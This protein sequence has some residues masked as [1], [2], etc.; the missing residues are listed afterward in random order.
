M[1]PLWTRSFTAL[2]VA[3]FFLATGFYLLLTSL[4]LYIVELGGTEAHV[5][6]LAFV[7]TISA[8]VLRP[9]VGGL[10][11]R[12]GRRQFVLGGLLLFAIS[13]FA[14]TRV[15]ELV[16]LTLV[17]VVHGLSWAITTTAIATAAS[18]VIPR[19][20]FG[21][22]MGWFG[23]S[24]TLGM[25]VGPLLPVALLPYI[26]YHGVFLVGC[27][28][29]V[30]SLMIARLAQMPFQPKERKPR[31]VLFNKA[32]LP[33]AA[34]VFFFAMVYSSIV[35]FLPLFAES[36]RV[37]KGLF[38]TVY[39]LF[40]LVVRAFSGRLA[41]RHGAAPV[42]VPGLVS[43]TL[44]MLVLWQTETV[45]GIVFAAILFSIAFGSAHPILQATALRLVPPGQKGVA[46]ATYISAFDLGIGLGSVLLGRIAEAQGF[47]AM[48]LA[49]ALFGAIALLIYL[50]F[51]RRIGGRELLQEA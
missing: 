34:T 51:A 10:L 7:F 31:V 47:A 5:G 40:L 29:A 50:Y 37:N 26:S 13:M 43:A 41:D 28:L 45:R 30:T 9:F 17:R 8:M 22:G 11:D 38:F 3:M 23:M 25:A 19:R 33:V 27:G 4:P 6:L 36:I 15:V 12:L 46:N 42:I 20:R 18:D 32:V 14:Y 35:T 24:T 21:E 2:T 44:T 48:F 39:A 16:P 49:T 1:Q